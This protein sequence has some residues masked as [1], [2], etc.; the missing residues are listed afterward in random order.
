[1]TMNEVEGVRKV[2][3]YDEYLDN[4]TP[5]MGRFEIGI[6]K[7]NRVAYISDNER[8]IKS[9]SENNS[10]LTLKNFEGEI[11]IPPTTGITI[12]YVARDITGITA[13]PIVVTEFSNLNLIIDKDSGLRL[14]LNTKD[15]VRLNDIIVQYSYDDPKSQFVENMFYEYRERYID[16]INKKVSTA[17]IK[18]NETYKKADFT[19][20]ILRVEDIDVCIHYNLAYLN[21][22]FGICNVYYEEPHNH[23]KTGV[24]LYMA[25]NH[26]RKLKRELSYINAFNSDANIDEALK[27]EKKI[28]K[29]EANI[30][31]LKTLQIEEQN[32]DRNTARKPENKPLENI[33]RKTDDRPLLDSQ[34]QSGNNDSETN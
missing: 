24:R 12:R 21:S 6:S 7:N 18:N 32:K 11:Y 30:E 15:I 33:L 23:T 1:M 3:I 28:A 26:N 19:N 4:D 16:H 25:Q 29:S 5:V 10:L 13:S 9:L 34:T 2:L 20:A 31:K 14:F 17:R 8:T 22:N 27:L